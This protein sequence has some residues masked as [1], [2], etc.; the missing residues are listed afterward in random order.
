M[1]YLP[2]FLIGLGLSLSLT[3]FAGIDDIT[4]PIAELGSCQSEEECFAYCDEP[5]NWDACIAFAEANDLLEEEEIDDYHQMNALM[6]EGGPGG[7]SS[8]A[9][10][11]AFC[12]DMG[13]MN[14]CISFAESH[15]MMEGE[16]LEEAKKV[17]AAL[18]AGYEMPGGCT[19]EQS[20][21]T[22]CQEPAHMEECLAFAEA[23][24]FMDA[25]EIEEMRAMSEVM[26]SGNTPGGCTDK[27][28]CEAYCEDPD[29]MDECLAFAVESGFMSA[30]EAEQ[31]KEHGMMGPEDFEGPGDCKG[32]TECKEYCSQEQNMQE[33]SDFFGDDFKDHE[34]DGPN[35]SHEDYGDKE[36]FTGPGGCTDESECMSYC[37]NPS[38]LEECMEFFEKMSGDQNREGGNHDDDD[39][40]YGS[41]DDH[42]NEDEEDVSHRTTVSSESLYRDT[43]ENGYAEVEEIY[44]D[45]SEPDE[46]LQKGIEQSGYLNDVGLEIHDGAL[47][48]G[49]DH[50]KYYDLSDIDIDLNSA[51]DQL[52]NYYDDHGGDKDDGGDHDSN[53][54]NDDYEK[55]YDDYEGDYG[56]DG[57]HDDDK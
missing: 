53:S 46:V 25:E 47:M 27:N 40:D 10:C 24:G 3:A 57:G 33:C 23:A 6:D 13:N 22:Y 44:F 34:D 42:E 49:D 51:I 15:G 32:E 29:H 20:C 41:D 4:F 54:G 17:L 11:E 26:L 5:G 37:S 7:C 16:E 19:D 38:N 8:D 52:N 45:N 35:D 28:S 39:E 30:E 56:D 2:V 18:D 50:E 14:E 43:D 9:E 55:S 1:K 12:G 48:L 36:S 31:A 21:E